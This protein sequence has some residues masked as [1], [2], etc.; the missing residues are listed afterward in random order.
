MDVVIEEIVGTEGL[1]RVGTMD[2]GFFKLDVDASISQMMKIVRAKSVE[3]LRVNLSGAVATKEFILKE[4]ADLGHHRFSIW[5]SGCS[6]LNAGEEIFLT[7]GTQ[8]AY[9]QLTSSDDHG[10]A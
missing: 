6:N 3:A 5:A 10:F 2:E 8:L 7:I 1:L 4:D 9:G